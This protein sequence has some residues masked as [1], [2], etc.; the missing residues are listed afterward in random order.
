[1]GFFLASDGATC[2][3][4]PFWANEDYLV[5]AD[6]HK[7]Y[8]YQLKPDTGEVR[9]ILM[10]P[11]SPVSFTFDPSTGVIYVICVERIPNTSQYKYRIR[12]KTFDGRIDAAIYNAPQGSTY[13]QLYGLALDADRGLLYYTDRIQGIVAEIT[14]S[15]SNRRQIF[16]DSTKRPR[17]IV[18]DSNSRR[19]YWSDCSG[20]ATIQTARVADGGDR[21]ILVTDGQSTCIVDIAVDFHNKLM[22]WVSTNDPAVKMASL[23][24]T[25]QVTL[26]QEPKADYTGITLYNNC[27][28]IS[29]SSRRNIIK[30]NLTSRAMSLQAPGLFSHAYD[31]KYFNTSTSGRSSSTPRTNPAFNSPAVSTRSTPAPWRPSSVPSTASAPLPSVTR[32]SQS[33]P[34]S[35]SGAG[36][37]TDQNLVLIV[38]TTAGVGGLLVLVVVIVVVVLI[39]VFFRKSRRSGE[40]GAPDPNAA[41]ATMYLAPLYDEVPGAVGQDN[42]TFECFDSKYESL[43][44][45]SRCSNSLAE[46]P[47]LKSS[48]PPNRPPPPPVKPKP[49]P[50]PEEPADH[51]DYIHFSRER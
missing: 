37:E 43:K 49:K 21:R 19:I 20:P 27:L 11:C 45:P 12:K 10:H 8:L 26:L 29:D 4:R 44:L 42:K 1:M 33:T 46:T 25:R 41:G 51:G 50:K 22:Y 39:C 38:A 24:G 3:S 9:A 7:Q 15:G 30:F 31:V 48:I 28:Y 35:T 36:A 23:N 2:T 16:S 13:S 47:P 6:Y 17:A 32:S 34:T 14:T 5:V 40:Q 18:V